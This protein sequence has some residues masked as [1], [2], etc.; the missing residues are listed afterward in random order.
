MA[1]RQLWF[2]R[3]LKLSRPRTCNGG[4]RSGANLDRESVRV[5]QPSAPDPLSLHLPRGLYGRKT[6]A[7]G[8]A[9]NLQDELAAIPGGI[10]VIDGD[11][12]SGQHGCGHHGL[13]RGSAHAARYQ[14]FLNRA[15]HA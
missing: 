1:A 10:D 8:K 3:P 12:Q 2:T 7:K 14:A 11:P 6:N 9:Q 4:R 5:R 13:G 15:G